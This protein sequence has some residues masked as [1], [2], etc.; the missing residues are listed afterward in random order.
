MNKYDLDTL[1]ATANKG[2]PEDIIRLAYRTFGTKMTFASSLG[3]EDQVL[4]DM[5]SRTHPDIEVFTL[6]TG[7]L[8]PETYDLMAHNK[9]HYNVPFKIVYPDSESV[10]KMVEKHGINL[11]YESVSNRKLCCDIRKV[12]PLKKALTDKIAWMTGLRRAQAVTRSQ[13]KFFEWDEANQLIKI[14]PLA[15]W[16][17]NDVNAY[18]KQHSVTINPLHER[19]FISIGCA[20]C[21]RA[22]RPGDDIRS[23]RWWW[24]QPEQR[25][26]GLHQQRK[27]AI[28]NLSPEEFHES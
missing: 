9:K 12:R 13:I 17:K 25:E 18:I 27:A 16:S 14:N 6:D 8:F 19:G 3:E 4:L 5:I 15:F 10:E 22:V 24:E 23:G 28:K 1:N 2:I 11:F 21:T 26:C 7:R 20:S